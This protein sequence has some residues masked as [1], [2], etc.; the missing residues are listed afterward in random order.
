MIKGID[1]SHWNAVT[2]SNFYPDCEFIIVKATEGKGYVDVQAKSHLTQWDVYCEK[3]GQPPLF[4]FYHFARPDIGNTWKEEAEHFL[5]RVAD[6]LDYK[7]VTFPYI[8]ALDVE[9]GAANKKYVTWVENWMEYVY[10]ATGVRPLLYTSASNTPQ[11]ESLYRKDYGLWV[12]HYNVKKPKTGPWPFYAI[13]QRDIE[14]CIDRDVF[15]G[16][17][18][19]YLKYCVNGERWIDND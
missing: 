17:P 3:V 16:T 4:G 2:D 11:Y 18:Q 14:K 10:G 9:A 15:N 6:I 1:L 5:E 7:Y 19:Q 12:A 8:M 13:W